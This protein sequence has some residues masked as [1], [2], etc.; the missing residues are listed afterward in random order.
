MRWPWERV[1]WGRGRGANASDSAAGD[2]DSPAPGSADPASAGAFQSAPA[3]MP[4]AWTRLP[5]LQRSVADSTAIAPPAAF[6]SSLTTHQNP[7]FLAPLGHLV[8]PDGP[9]GVVG[10]L[11]SSVGGPI[12]Y[13]GVDELRVPERPAPPSAPA[14]QRRI[15]TLRP[16]PTG[17]AAPRG[18]GRPDRTAPA[19]AT[20]RRR[21]SPAAIET[22]TPTA[23]T[24]R[25]PRP[26]EPAALE[27][28]PPAP[29]VVARSAELAPAPDRPVAGPA[30]LRQRRPGSRPA[31]GTGRPEPARRRPR[32]RRD[33]GRPCRWPVAGPGR[34]GSDVGSGPR[35]P[36]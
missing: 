35:R 23:P 5:P 14:V 32:R 6:R 31:L 9:A 26:S 27:T 4:A 11:A 25:D 22:G 28:A 36:R 8:D 30:G 24:S 15:A 34:G 33:R 2:A 1:P 18:R 10:G 21:P 17:G 13:E 16:E 7:S 19:S 12:P 20:T 3:A 29:L